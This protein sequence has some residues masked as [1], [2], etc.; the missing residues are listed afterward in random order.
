MSKHA[1]SGDEGMKQDA[2]PEDSMKQDAMSKCA[3]KKVDSTKKEMARKDKLS[4]SHRLAPTG[5]ACN[6]QLVMLPETV[7]YFRFLRAA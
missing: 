2:M 5:R 7:G 3:I 4:F 6:V 1:M